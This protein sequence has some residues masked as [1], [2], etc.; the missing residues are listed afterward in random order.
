M[1]QI[2]YRGSSVVA[3]VVIVVVAAAAAAVVVVVV[4]VISVLSVAAPGEDCGTE[5]RA[6]GVRSAFLLGASGWGHCMA[7]AQGWHAQIEELPSCVRP[8]T[9]AAVAW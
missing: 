8:S 9:N 7:P 2:G 3:V 5:D 4:I 1:S 6:D